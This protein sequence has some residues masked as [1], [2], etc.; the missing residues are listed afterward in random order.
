MHSWHI[1]LILSSCKK[2]AATSISEAAAKGYVQNFLSGILEDAPPI[3]QSGDLL[4][5]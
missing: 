4:T 5:F 1:L 2:K 3:S